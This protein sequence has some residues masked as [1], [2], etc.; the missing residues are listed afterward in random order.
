MIIDESYGLAFAFVLTIN[1]LLLIHWV[2]NYQARIRES[3]LLIIP[4]YTLLIKCRSTR[5]R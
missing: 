2:R 3:L 4:L 5:L 1:E